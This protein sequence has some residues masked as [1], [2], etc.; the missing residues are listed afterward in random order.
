MPTECAGGKHSTR[1]YWDFTECRWVCERV[2]SVAVAVAVAGEAGP[3]ALGGVGAL[4]TSA[5]RA[6]EGEFLAPPTSPLPG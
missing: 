3:E 2:S 6:P 1:C 5:T 4:G